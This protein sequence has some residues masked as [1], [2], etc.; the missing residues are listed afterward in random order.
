MVTQPM[1]PS[2]RARL[3]GML[4]ELA[5]QGYSQR[6]LARAFGLGQSTVASHLLRVGFK[7][8]KRTNQHSRVDA[9]LPPLDDHISWRDNESA[10]EP[11][12]APPGY[13]L[14]LP[15]RTISNEL[16][17][18]QQINGVVRLAYDVTNA[19][20]AGDKAWVAG[21]REDLDATAE[22]VRRLI[23]VI[24]DDELRHRARTDHGE[25]DDLRPPTLR[26]VVG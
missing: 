9:S 20:A 13:T 25:R 19:L 11:V 8:T 3:D 14:S 12:I 2:E 15:A 7:F 1:S 21:V 6:T 4:L 23:A 16:R 26:R 22:Y 5:K 18:L 24:D 17:H 10:P